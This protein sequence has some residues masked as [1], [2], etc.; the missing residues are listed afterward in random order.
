MNL[1]KPLDWLA[2]K[3][4]STV[5]LSDKQSLIDSRDRGF[6]LK[7]LTFSVKRVMLLTENEN[8]AKWIF[9]DISDDKQ[10]LC[11]MAK[12]VN[13]EVDFR[14]YY[15]SEDFKATTRQGAID[16]GDL[17]LFQ[18]PSNEHDF[19]PIELRY[20]MDIKQTL[21]SK[22]ELNYSQKAQKEMS[23]SWT[24]NPPR[25]GMSNM[26]ATIVEYCTDVECENPEMMILEVGSKFNVNGGEVALYL[27]TRINESEIQ[28][29]PL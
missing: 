4:G 7:P 21:K 2:L 10:P 14:V 1:R 11:L 6:G 20:T 27:G 25:D 13:E 8:M 17:W 15:L 23:G 19:K 12:Y 5:L 16:R 18:K 28:V 26:L 29:L 24:E 9:V 3:S 22:E